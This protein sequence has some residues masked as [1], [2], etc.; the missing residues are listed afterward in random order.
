MFNRSQS[1][2]V[3][4]VEAFYET[5]FLYDPDSFGKLASLLADQHTTHPVLIT[6][7]V[8]VPRSRDFTSDACS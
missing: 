6:N 5:P 1:W 8:C 4:A 2:S 3:P 7:T